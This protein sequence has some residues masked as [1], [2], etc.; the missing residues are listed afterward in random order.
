VKVAR[1]MPHRFVLRL[2]TMNLR[3]HRK[4]LV[5]DGTVGFTGGM[6]IRQ[7]NMLSENPKSP[8]KDMHFRVEGPVVRQLQRAF[9]EDWAFCADE[10]L[11]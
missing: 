11:E 1:F 5:I 8:V 2:L 10:I 4:I 6:N 7:G 9:A 3:N